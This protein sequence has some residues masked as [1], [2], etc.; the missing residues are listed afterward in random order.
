MIHNHLTMEIKRSDEVIYAHSDLLIL[1]DLF[2]W[3]MKTV[4]RMRLQSIRTGNLY[5]YIAINPNLTSHSQ[6]LEYLEWAC[7]Q[8]YIPYSILVNQ[9]PSKI[10]R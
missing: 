3:W 6:H 1:E 7:M 8:Y 10:I 5:L 4:S 2:P 9:N